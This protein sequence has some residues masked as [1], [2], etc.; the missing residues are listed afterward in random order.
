MSEPSNNQRSKKICFV[1]QQSPYGSSAS[2]EGLEALLA[3]SAY[4]QNLSVIFMGDG[5]FQLIKDQRS[6]LSSRKSMEKML[7][8]LDLYDLPAP[9]VCSQALKKRQ[10]MQDN[11]A[12]DV[13]IQSPEIIHQHLQQQDTVFTF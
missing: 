8:A 11:I 10:L 4:D 5:V 1:F 9:L 3:F 7:S 6:E 13:S 12:I 2:H